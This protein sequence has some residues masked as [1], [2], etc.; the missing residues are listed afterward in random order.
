[1]TAF[2]PK[3]MWSGSFAPFVEQSQDRGESISSRIFCERT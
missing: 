3:T 1:M 2:I